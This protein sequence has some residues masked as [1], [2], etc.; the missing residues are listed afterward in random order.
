[1]EFDPN[2]LDDEQLDA[3]LR[4][5]SI[6]SDLKDS[7]RQVP[8]MP[9]APKDTIDK[10]HELKTNSSTNGQSFLWMMVL[11]ASLAAVAAFVAWQWYFSP[12]VNNGANLAGTGHSNSI[13]DDTAAVPTAD[14]VNEISTLEELD[15]QIAALNSMLDQIEMEQLEQRVLVAKTEY[16]SELSDR[17]AQSIIIALSSQISLP[18]GG[19]EDSVKSEMAQ[20]MK[21]F[22][23]S[24]GAELA[25]DYLQQTQN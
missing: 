23:G 15:L 3:L 14:M 11:A 25:R 20:V 19:K 22:P 13:H 24:V 4:D 9:V 6:P 17:E 7:L 12:S 1:M 10:K 18:L 2:Q 5:V 8:Q 16:E 21:K